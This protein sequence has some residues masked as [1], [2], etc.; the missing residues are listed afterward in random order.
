MGENAHLRGLPRWRLVVT[1]FAT[2][3]LLVLLVRDLGGGSDFLQAVRSAR[4]AWVGLA[5]LA[6]SACVAL[7]AWRWSLVLGAM[8]YS[9]PIGRSLNVLLAVWPLAVVTPSRTNELLRPLLV[10]DIV[11]LAEGAGS[12]LAEKAI[13]L[14]VL[15]VFAAVGASLQRQ[16][17][18]AGIIS[19]AIIAEALVLVA[20][21]MRRDWLVRLPLV[22][23]RP[24]TVD[25]I[26]G[27]Y[28]AFRRE[29]AR[30]VTVACVSLLIRFL[31][32]AITYALLIAVGSDVGFFDTVTLWPAAMLVG[33]APLT[34]AGM[35]TRDA[36]FIY[37]LGARGAHV[38][39][40]AVLAATMGYSAVAIWSFAIL[41]I[42][43]M[44]RV[45]LGRADPARQ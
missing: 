28:E 10:R 4:A 45:A 35:G 12:V 21:A 17:A 14:F 7:G 26:F 16:W 31:T 43:L 44:V 34:L 8:G 42:P 2:V 25:E 5:F 32:V 3:A 27:A 20:L 36:A 19:A 40:S 29:P 37:L 15:L 1:L 23:R 18:L 39:R 6:A 33:L 9:L 41:G 11:P 38:S 22:R 13:D 24:Q 30:L